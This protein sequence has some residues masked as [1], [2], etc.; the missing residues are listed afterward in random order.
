MERVEMQCADEAFALRTFVSQ[1][2]DEDR[3]ID[4]TCQRCGWMQRSAE[5]G[6]AELCR[7]AA[8]HDEA[9]Y[10]RYAEKA[11]QGGFDVPDL[12]A[13]LRVDGSA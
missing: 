6:A 10:R 4:Y 1:G 11:R 5:A 7:S 8:W 12:P 3:Q 9:T 2:K 13:S